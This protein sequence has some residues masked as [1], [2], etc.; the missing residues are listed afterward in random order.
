LL[1][2]FSACTKFEDGGYYAKSRLAGE[3]K[4]W[5]LSDHSEYL[6]PYDLDLTIAMQQWSNDC[7]YSLLPFNQIDRIQFD[8][9]Y[10]GLVSFRSIASGKFPINWSYNKKNNKLIIEIATN[11]IF[12]E[13]MHNEFTILKL[14]K[15]DLWLS[16]KEKDGTCI[17]YKFWNYGSW[18]EGGWGLGFII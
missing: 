9:D 13:N 18:D 11:G 12:S 15:K 14:T 5:T 17:V 8:K 2:S 6:Q 1:V 3:K 4:V 7:E 16:C 10:T